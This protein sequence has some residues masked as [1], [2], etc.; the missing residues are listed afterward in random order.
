M[1]LALSAKDLLKIQEA[2]D[3]F[4]TFVGNPLITTFEIGKRDLE[5]VATLE[6][7]RLRYVHLSFVLLLRYESSSLCQ[8]HQDQCLPKPTST[9]SPPTCL[10]FAAIPGIRPLRL[11]PDHITDL[12]MPVQ[13]LESSESVILELDSWFTPTD[14]L[15]GS[16]VPKKRLN[17]I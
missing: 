12:P 8:G 17:W 15:L 4:K 9:S 1:F 10:Q 13:S 3:S 5:V 2:E 16:I 11:N 6:P 7:H 14:Q